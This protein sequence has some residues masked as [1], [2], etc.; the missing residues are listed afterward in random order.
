MISSFLTL[1][2]DTVLKTCEKAGFRPTG[3]FTQLNSYENRVFDIQLEASDS[4][5]MENIIAKFYRPE[6]WSAAA[7]IEEH[8][9]LGELNE[10]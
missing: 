1:D 6:R 10:A 5:P 9:F 7:V 3:I 8:Q 2:P 4:G